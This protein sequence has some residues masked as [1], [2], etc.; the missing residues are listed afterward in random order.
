MTFDPY[1]LRC[2]VCDRDVVVNDR[3]QCPVCDTDVSPLVGWRVHGARL[4][5]RAL[6]AAHEGCW[7]RASAL[8]EESRELLPQFAGAAL[9][10]GK[11][12]GYL[13]RTE[14]A[15]EVLSLSRRLGAP[16]ERVDQALAGLT[17]AAQV[18]A[19]TS[20]LLGPLRHA[21]IVLVAVLGVLAAL[22]AYLLGRAQAPPPA[23]VETFVTHVVTATALVVQADVPNPTPTPPPTPT[24][25][26]TATPIPPTPT[27]Q[28]PTPAPCP[29]LSTDVEAALQAQPE[30]Q[31]GDLSVEAEGC[32]VVLRGAVPTQHLL[33][34]AVQ[35]LHSAGAGEV[36]VSDVAVTGTY[37][38][39]RADTLWSIAAAVYGDSTMWPTIY[40]A[41]GD[42]IED[43]NIV[44]PG[45]E[46]KLP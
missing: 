12:L 27:L 5:N 44:R 20:R 41:N 14:E 16:Q 38:V 17:A 26:P 13:G 46:L 33:D 11:V 1:A 15:R 32:T 37:R 45:V 24:P 40:Q 21:G 39:R 29:G 3:F 30:L 8:L 34:L 42:R 2:P 23:Y 22:G 36:S 43:P 19:G 18:D 31:I 25:S 4:Y 6:T 10:H 35:T 28:P 7:E 9:V